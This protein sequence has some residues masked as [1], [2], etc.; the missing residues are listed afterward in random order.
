MS[1]QYPVVL[2][3][4][5]RRC[6]VVGGGG[7]AGAK[8][9]GLVDAGAA[10][11]VVAPS[12]SDELASLAASGAV[13]H[14]A[15]AYQAG[16]LA[17]AFLAIATGDRA[18][19]ASVCAEARAGG[20]LVNAVDDIEHCDFAAPSIVRRGDLTIS[21]STAGR[22]PALARRLRE[23]LSAQ[24]GE[25]WGDLVAVLAEARAA[26]IAGREAG[27]DTWAARWR[28]ALSWDLAGMVRDGRGEEARDLVTAVLEGAAAAAPG[29]VAIVGA[30][31]GDPGLI[32]VRGR[33]LLAV[34]DVVVYDRLV[35]PSLWAG[36]EAID[37]GKEAG[38]HR[39]DQEG[40][41]ALLVALARA[42]RFVV[43]LKGGDP[44]V[45][46]RGAEEAEAL[47]RAGIPF[48]VVPAPSS[49][50]AALAAAGIPVTDRRHASSVA[51]VT[52]HCVAGAVDWPHLAAGADTLVVLMGLR[53]LEEIVAALLAAGRDPAT[54]SAVVENGTLAS[55]RVVVAGLADLPGEVAAAGLKSP[56]VIVVGEVVRVR[57]RLAGLAAARFNEVETGR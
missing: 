50:V 43:R 45:F 30:G 54:P 32:T 39:V 29:R 31:P 51:V 9:R 41:N 34:A 46:G 7:V 19:N 53:H 11:T 52:G 56:S 57:E 8:V 26:G 3:L 38:S 40:I 12:V 44:F 27:F 22:A 21:V 1:F 36:K 6:V 55:Q 4:T 28:Q 35:H 20:V 13:T 24:F 14:V 5:D 33:D 2:D 15:R 37:A 18:E 42:G 16:D 23:V 17:G 48:E 49:A 47:A 25:E 10:V